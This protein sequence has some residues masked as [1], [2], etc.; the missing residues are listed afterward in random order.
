MS[1]S[2]QLAAGTVSGGFELPV[3]FEEL[4]EGA[5]NH[6][7]TGPRLFPRE[8]RQM[9]D[10]DLAYPRTASGQARHQFGRDKRSFG[11]QLDPVE[12]LTPK[13]LETA[14]NIADAETEEQPYQD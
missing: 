5:R 9:P 12:N 13:E 7:Q 10:F 1:S 4:A 8:S 3:K 2:R 14:I 6:P 11:V